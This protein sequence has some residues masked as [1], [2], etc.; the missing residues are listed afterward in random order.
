MKIALVHEPYKYQKFTDKNYTGHLKFNQISEG[1]PNEDTP[2]DLMYAS[3]LL[4]E[5]GFETTIIDAEGE[6]INKND[7]IKRVKN[8]EADVVAFL[9]NYTTTGNIA[10]DWIKSIKESKDIITIVWR[11]TTNQYASTLLDLY[12]IDYVILDPGLKPL[13][14]LLKEIRR[15]NENLSNINGIA[16]RKDGE[17]IIN[18][19]KN[20]EKDLSKLPWPDR[21]NVNPINNKV[22]FTKSD[23]KTIVNTSTGCPFDC[24]FCEYGKMSVK[25][26]STDDVLLELKDI[27]MDKKIKVIRFGDPNFLIDKDRTRNISKGII[28]MELEFDWTC[29]ARVDSVDRKTLKLMKEAGCQLIW[30]GIESGSQKILNN[31]NKNID[32]MDTKKSIDLTRK[33][34]IRP[35]GFFIIGSPGETEKEIKRTIE[36]AKELPLFYAQFLKMVARPGTNLYEDVKEELGYDYFEKLIKGEVEP[37]E[38]PRPWT[39]LTNKEIDYWVK[40]GFKEFYLRPSQIIKILGSVRSFKELRDYLK[41]GIRLLKS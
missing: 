26:R 7:T 23:A 25:R 1:C 13:L 17:K 37:M 2:I 28:N 32:L 33:S 29:M 11:G 38:L 8:S 12:F 31:L 41:E 16:Y 35:C 15:G 20:S 22:L 39:N 27:V 6:K 9:V 3:S 10:L 14:K 19:P 21:K 18:S 5:G 34:G 4:K 24:N 30:Y 40:R 36:F